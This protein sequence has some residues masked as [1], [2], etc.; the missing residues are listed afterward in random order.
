MNKR[1][2]ERLRRLWNGTLT[3]PAK[4]L[5]R[6]YQAFEDSP[7]IKTH[8]VWQEALKVYEESRRVKV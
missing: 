7:S 3:E 4:A 5:E 1:D 8:S 6:A 2:E